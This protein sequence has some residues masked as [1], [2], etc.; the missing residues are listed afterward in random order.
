MHLY[1]YI[2]NPCTSFL[3]ETRGGGTPVRR[4]ILEEDYLRDLRNL[5]LQHPL[6]L[7]EIT[8]TLWPHITVNSLYFSK[9]LRNG[10][11]GQNSA[12]F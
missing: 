1:I 12:Y 10:H 7:P 11:Y 5:A 8:G 6:I 4:Q 2:Y 9:E 3:Q